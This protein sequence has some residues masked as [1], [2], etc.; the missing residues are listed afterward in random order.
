MIEALELA[1]EDERSAQE[2]YR[3]MAAIAED[4]E[5]R[6]MFEQMA[7]EEQMH[8]RR[9]VEKLKALKLMRG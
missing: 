7:R 5:T 9:L 4:A 2:K 3:E 6:L 8:Y 1:I